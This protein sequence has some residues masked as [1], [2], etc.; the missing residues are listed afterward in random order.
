[1][2]FTIDQENKKVT[3]G[4]DDE[5]PEEQHYEAKDLIIPDKVYDDE[6]NDYSIEFSYYAF[7][8]KPDNLY[9]D[10]TGKL[11]LPKIF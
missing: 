4:G 6:G 7:C 11:S 9:Y 5:I 8:N 1:M 10:L 3:Y 2:D